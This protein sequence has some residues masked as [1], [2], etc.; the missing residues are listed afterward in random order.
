[1]NAQLKIRAAYNKGVINPFAIDMSDKGLKS[2]YN[3]LLPGLCHEIGCS[4]GPRGEK[5]PHA[6]TY[7]S[8]EYGVEDEV[9]DFMDLRYI[10]L[11]G[12]NGADKTQKLSLTNPYQYET[13]GFLE[14]WDNRKDPMNVV[15]L[16]FF[17]IENHLKPAMDYHGLTDA[18]L[19][20]RRA[21]QKEIRVRFHRH[22]NAFSI[23]SLR[24]NTDYLFLPRNDAKKA[25]LLNVE[26]IVTTSSVLRWDF[27][28]K[29]NS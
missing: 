22:S 18:P 4:M 23:D 2:G 28:R 16:F 8:F 1:M 6:M 17:Y 29:R 5:E 21:P 12:F 14:M 9:P 20:N 26:F 15:N 11:M 10:R 19:F 3:D 13:G 27:L 25:S 7:S 24:S